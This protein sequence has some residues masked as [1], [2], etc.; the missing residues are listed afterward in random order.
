MLKSLMS[1]RILAGVLVLL[2][3][4]VAAGCGHSAPSAA[5]VPPRTLSI[6]DVT[7][8]PIAIATV[9]AF[10]YVSAGTRS[11]GSAAP[12]SGELVVTAFAFDDAAGWSISAPSGWT[13]YD[14][15][16]GG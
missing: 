1:A 15:P 16:T 2:A 5:Y 7:P 6:R 3:S 12:T 11:V 8:T 9:N 13:T 4:A 14:S 10:G